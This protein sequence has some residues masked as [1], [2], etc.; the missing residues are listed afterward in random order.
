MNTIDK[1]QLFN[2]LDIN[3]AEKAWK[4]MFDGVQTIYPTG[5]T[6]FSKEIAEKFVADF[7]KKYNKLA[8]KRK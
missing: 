8:G 2:G 7:T 6:F 4:K 5:I 3:R 1:N